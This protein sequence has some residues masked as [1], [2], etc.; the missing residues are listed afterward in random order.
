MWPFLEANI[1]GHGLP[2]NQVP[3]LIKLIYNTIYL[4]PSYVGDAL[5]IVGPS[6]V[7]FSI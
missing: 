2:F 6:V 3:V 7:V 1:Y 5:K 4:S